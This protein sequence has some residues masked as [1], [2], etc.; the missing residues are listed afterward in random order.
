M[1]K[2]GKKFILVVLVQIF[3]IIILG[4]YFYLNSIGGNIVLL[5]IAPVDPRDLLRGDYMQI[6]FDISNLSKD[7]ISGT[8]VSQ[9]GQYVYV[10]L[11]KD[12]DVYKVMNFSSNKPLKGI[13]IKGKVKDS[14]F[15]DSIPVD[16]G[17]EQYFI[18]EGTGGIMG[19]KLGQNRN[20]AYAEVSLDK[21]GV[22]ILRKLIIG[23]EEF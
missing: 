14:W 17:I 13:F 11:E 12:G 3:L 21:D 20:N 10:S 9:P 1:E 8:Y 5:K 4:L 15:G 2:R 19:Q 6:R 22:P 16:Y 18:P 23:K 7:L